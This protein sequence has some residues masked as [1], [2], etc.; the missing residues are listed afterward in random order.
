[1]VRGYYG[2][3][4]TGLMSE[5]TEYPG[6][7]TPQDLYDALL[8]VWCEYTC[9][10]RLRKDFACSH[11]TL[12]ACAIT[13]FLA[14]DIFGGDVYGIPLPEGGFHCFNKVG[15]HLFDLT[16]EQFSEELNY[17][18]CAMQKREE[19]FQ[20][21]EKEER[22]LYLKEHLKQYCLEHNGEQNNA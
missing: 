21:K 16:S 19:H 18:N 5:R 22:Y 4:D 8:N 15:K 2:S 12:G 3:E 17:D 9:T 1:M 14:Q 10:P 7:H 20:R 11:K 6:T 13:A